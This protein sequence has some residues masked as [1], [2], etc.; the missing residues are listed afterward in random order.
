MTEGIIAAISAITVGIIS[1]VSNVLIANATQKKTNE[2]TDYRIGELKDQVK[3]LEAKQDKHNQ[4]IERTFRLEEHTAVLDEK[5]KEV[6]NRIGG[7]VR[8]TK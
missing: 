6:N 2:F 4:V 5:I 3:N 7:L 8:K 1:A